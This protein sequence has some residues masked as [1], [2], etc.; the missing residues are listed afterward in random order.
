MTGYM[1]GAPIPERRGSWDERE[2]RLI[3]GIMWRLPWFNIHPDGRLILKPGVS[4]VDTVRK[5]L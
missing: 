5:W 3:V 2:L 4:A 1:Y